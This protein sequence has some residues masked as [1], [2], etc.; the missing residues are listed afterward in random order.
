MRKPFY[1]LKDNYY[2]NRR[3]GDMN[4]MD[5]N[6]IP[7][8]SYIRNKLH[9]SVVKRIKITEDEI[10]KYYNSINV[11]SNVIKGNIYKHFLNIYRNK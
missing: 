5:I 2:L 1:V 6:E 4:R 9:V 8:L 11:I 7:D 3:S 10:N